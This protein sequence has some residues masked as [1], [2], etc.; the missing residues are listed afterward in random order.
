M[1][2]RDCNAFGSS[3]HIAHRDENV[4][5]MTWIVMAA[6]LLTLSVMADRADL[7]DH[8]VAVAL[9][10]RRGAVGVHTPQGENLVIVCST[11]LSE[12]G[13]VLVTDI[14]SGET[15]QIWA[16]ENVPNGAA[17]GSCV[18]DSGK[19]YTGQGDWLLEFDPSTREWTFTGRPAPGASSYLRIIQGPEGKIW[20]G[21]VY[22]AGLSCYDPQ[23]GEMTDYG[24]MDEE[25]YCSKIAFDDAGWIYCGIG[26]ARTNLVAFNPETE[27]KRSL[28]P[29]E[30]REVGTGH[31]YTSTDGNAYGRSAGQWYR[32]HDGEAEPIDESARGSE[33]DMGDLYWGDLKADFPDGRSVTAY[34][35]QQKYL[36]VYNPETE[37]TRTIPFDY[38]SEGTVIRVLTSGPGEM[39]YGNSAHPSRFIA[40]DPATETLEYRPGPIALKGFAVQGKYVFGG[41]YG[42]GKLYVYDTTRPWNLTGR[43]EALK[44]AIRAQRLVE[45]GHTY[46]GRLIYLDSHD[47]ALFLADEYDG[48]AFFDL[49]LEE[50][51]EYTLLI[52]TY[53][54][55]SYCTVQLYLDGEK[56]GEPFDARG[57]EV[58]AG[59]VLSFGPFDLE[60]GPHRLKVRTVEGDSENPW[61]SLRAVKFSRDLAD[62]QV[63]VPGKNPELVETFSPDINVPWGAAAH[64]DGKHIMISGKPGYG[65]IGGGI[66]IYSLETGESQLLTH[67]QL[68]E[69]HSVETMAPLPDGNIVCGTSVSGGHGTSAVA[70]DAV[71][72]LLDWNS[73]S[74]A[75][76]E[77]PVEGLGEIRKIVGGESG[78]VYCLGT[79]SQL[80]SYDLENRQIVHSVDLSEYGGVPVNPMMMDDSGRINI[81][82][83]DAVLTVSP[84]EDG[85]EVTKVCDA[86]GSINAGIGRAKGRIYFAVGSHLWST[87]VE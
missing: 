70:T 33:K 11:D 68:I 4:K 40:Y 54:A 20:L 69:N 46:D 53:R 6:V 82:M 81:T 38:E 86:P 3:N 30:K 76:T 71:I 80:F 15:E 50:A 37:T 60:A 79:N 23:T 32:L 8:G 49:P 63:Q 84:A 45:A 61:I 13:W 73:K 1:T 41:H 52:A 10:E 18:A 64:P 48:E 17:F 7:T 26:T 65:R 78:I 59:P 83:S 85:L 42:G 66:G 62:A 16:P 77:V 25:K 75:W 2:S 29:D 72:F 31:T 39:I 5:K 44:G 74:V 55:P 87:V 9:A 28:I 22:R 12:R 27:E 57:A 51:G 35:L 34:N 56:L 43:A 24:P 36:D 67:E 14:D 21:D 19:F 58:E 47:V